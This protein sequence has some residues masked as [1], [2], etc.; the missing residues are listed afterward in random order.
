MQREVQTA[1]E[2]EIERSEGTQHH[3]TWSSTGTDTA[4]DSE[5]VH[6]DDGW[7]SMGETTEGETTEDDEEEKESS[8][9]KT[10]RDCRF[11]WF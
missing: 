8:K 1:S 7:N 9:E 10:E 11:D 5:P 6:M 2:E 4:T 3:Y